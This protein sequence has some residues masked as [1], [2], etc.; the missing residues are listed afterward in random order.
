MHR[1]KSVV[2]RSRKRWIDIVRGILGYKGV[3]QAEEIMYDRSACGGE[4]GG[5]VLG[6][7]CLGTDE[8]R[9]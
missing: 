8:P 5:G 7:L 1:L 2:G 4:R 9:S 6:A 3:K